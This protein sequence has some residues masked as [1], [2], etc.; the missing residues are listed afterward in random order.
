MKIAPG[1]KLTDGRFDVVVIGNLGARKILANAPRIYL[2]S[3]LSMDQVHHALAKKVIARAA[4]KDQEIAVEID[5]ELAGSLP[6]TF[7]ILPAALR[8]R[9]PAG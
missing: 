9:C 8:V 4:V 2:G 5:G 6:A 7:Q 1:A 3:H